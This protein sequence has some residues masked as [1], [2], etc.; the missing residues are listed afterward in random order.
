MFRDSDNPSDIDYQDGRGNSCGSDTILAQNLV[1][2]M[3]GVCSTEHTIQRCAMMKNLHDIL[4]NHGIS[5]D[6]NEITITF[7]DLNRANNDDIL[8]L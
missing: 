5:M 3:R 4:Q 2:N 6:D 1:K 7:T 8:V